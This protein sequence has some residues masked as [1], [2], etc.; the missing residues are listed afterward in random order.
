MAWRDTR[1]SRRRLLL[2]STSIVMGIAA[3]VAIRSFATSAERAIDEQSRALLGADLSITSRRALTPEDE[4]LFASLGGEQAREIDF[5]AMLN[6]PKSAAHQG[7]VRL[8][9]VRATTTNYPFYGNFE[10]SPDEAVR[11]FRSGVGVLLE[12]SLLHQ[13]NAQVGDPVRLGELNSVI[14]GTIKRAPGDSAALAAL[15]PRVYLAM[16]S[17]ARTGLLRDGSLARYRVHFKF[18]PG[19]DVRALVEKVRPTLR[20]QRL[21]FH[22]V[23]TRKADLGRSVDDV[24][25]YLHLAGLVALLLG[26]IGVAS[27]IH[28]HIKAKLETAAVLRCL[29]CSVAQTF[30][31]YLSQ[32]V[33]VGLIGAITGAAIGILLQRAVQGVL[34]G[35]FPFQISVTTDWS[36]IAIA[37]AQGLLSAVLF[38]LLPLLDV[39]RVSPLAAIR[40]HY[41]AGRVRHDW[42]VWL[43]YALI[44]GVMIGFCLLHSRTWKQGLIFAGGLAA[45]FL[46][47]ACLARA[48]VWLTR[49]CSF[50]LLPYV[51]R[52]GL[53]NLHRPQNRTTLLVLSLG[54][55]TFLILSIFLVQRSLVGEL[56][57]ARGVNSPNIAFF[58]I[59]S[60]QHPGVIAILGSNGVP[61]LDHAPVV[62]MRLSSI[63]DQRVETILADTNRSIPGWALRREYRSTY[64]DGL[65]PGEKLLAGKWPVANSSDETTPISIEK[66]IAQELGV[67]LGDEITFDVQGIPMT[68]RIHA[69]R[70]VDWR[71]VQPNFF[72]VFPPSALRDAPASH[73]VTSR[74]GSPAQSAQLQRSIVEAFP[75]VSAIDVSLVLQTL[76]AIF[77][78]ISFAVQFMASFTIVTGLLVLIGTILTGRYQRIRESVLLRSLGASRWQVLQVLLA[79]H[80]ALG[81]LSAGVGVGL[82][83]AAG[84]ALTHFVFRVAFIPAWGSL[85]CAIIIV[86]AVSAAIG[87]LASRGIL[88]HPPLQVLRAE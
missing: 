21:N 7:G 30:A 66:G 27:G 50:R 37:I 60:D 75:N 53:A 20:E 40:A 31:I 32:A 59:Q 34:A 69:I 5:S 47:L 78:R 9:Q 48:T 76:D 45:A 88:N 39:R 16:D 2:F 4:Q 29:G 83:A 13:F 72:V 12:P 36:G 28:V 87:L 73:I 17:V 70:E 81:V 19:T 61:I 54:L 55:G 10:S 22:T 63:E 23:E 67:T 14:A 68:G 6:F 85:V 1:A 84:W 35:F 79:E 52:Q 38:A 64:A 80:L 77:S 82:A 25:N 33:L 86:P 65:R 71:R 3:L 49:R 42:T 15:S 24:S 41:Q 44:T 11:A 51:W 58:D 43:I 26:G 62:T 74:V 8:V 46:A 57:T 18:P 56:I